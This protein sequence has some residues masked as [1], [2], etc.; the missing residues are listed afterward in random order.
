M[1]SSQRPSRSPGTGGPPVGTWKLLEAVGQ[2]TD[3]EGLGAREA[4]EYPLVSFDE[5]DT[6][7]ID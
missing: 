7:P 2:D 6:E 4:V 3:F 5:E 1:W